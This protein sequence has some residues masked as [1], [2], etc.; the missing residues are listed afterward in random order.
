MYNG[1]YVKIMII[2]FAIRIII[3][4]VV[5]KTGNTCF[6]NNIAAWSSGSSPVS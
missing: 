1:K 4:T 5:V 2:S 6:L 3:Y